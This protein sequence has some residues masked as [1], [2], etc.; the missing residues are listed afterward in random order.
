[1][2]LRAPHRGE[3]DV[4][5]AQWLRAP[6]IG[7]EESI[8]QQLL[9]LGDALVSRPLGQCEVTEK[10]DPRTQAGHG[11]VRTVEVAGL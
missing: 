11:I 10:D 6:Q 4:V 9:D 7:V 5:G 8:G 3:R 2:A 1:M